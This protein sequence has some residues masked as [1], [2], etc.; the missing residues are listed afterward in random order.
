AA[1]LPSL[2]SFPTR[3]SSDLVIWA[4]LY[5]PS[6][7]ADGESYDKLLSETLESREKL[8]AEI[9]ALKQANAGEANPEDVKRVTALTEAA[10][11]MRSEEHTSELQSRF[12]LVCR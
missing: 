10:Q 4:L 6:T 7:N 3:R 11:K 9:D 2:P 5:F 1:Y 8:G 12:D